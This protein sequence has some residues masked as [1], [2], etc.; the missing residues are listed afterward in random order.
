[1]RHYNVIFKDLSANKMDSTTITASNVGQA[2]AIFDESVKGDRDL[3]VI[4]IREY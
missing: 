2:M 3:K 1:M 4:S